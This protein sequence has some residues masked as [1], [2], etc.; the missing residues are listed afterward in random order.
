[1]TCIQLRDGVVCGAGEE[2]RIL[3]DGRFFTFEWHAYFGPS[4]L[5]RRGNPLSVQPMKVVK[6]VELWDRQGRQLDDQGM[7]CCVWP[8]EIPPGFRI[9]KI[10]R[11]Q[12]IVPI[13]EAASKEGAA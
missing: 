5:G 10:G 3:V 7:C 6:A 1:M 13:V 2:Y 4:V 12:F 9:E 11:H 8:E